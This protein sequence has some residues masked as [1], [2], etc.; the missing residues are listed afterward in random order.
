MPRVEPAPAEH[1]I[2]MDTFRDVRI[3]GGKYVAFV[4][5]AESFQRSPAFSVPEPAQPWAHQVRQ[6]NEIA[7]KEKNKTP[8]L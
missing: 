4:L 7:D 5:T 6:Q 3:L 1:A 2:K 8:V